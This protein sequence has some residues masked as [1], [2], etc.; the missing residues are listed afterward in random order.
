MFHATTQKNA[1][2]IIRTKM[3][4]SA[5]EPQVFVSNTARVSRDYGDGSVVRVAVPRGLLKINDVFPRGRKDYSIWV[6]SR[7]CI[8]LADA[9]IVRRPR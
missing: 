6:G 7:R 1:L 4:C 5:G 2:E 9:E 3:L 8:P